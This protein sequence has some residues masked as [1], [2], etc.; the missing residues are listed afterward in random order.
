MK[1]EKYTRREFF[2][3]GALGLGAVF[4]RSPR[5]VLS[6]AL[7]SPSPNP[8]VKAPRTF[9]VGSQKGV[10]VHKLP[11]DSSLIMYQRGYNDIIN[12]YD[13]V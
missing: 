4:L 9:L 8:G 13:Q 2:K 6:N 7:V 11:D 1:K 3:L 5:L 10:S 12:V